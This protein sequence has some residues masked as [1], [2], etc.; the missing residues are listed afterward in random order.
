MPRTDSSGEYVGVELGGTKMV[1]ATSRGGALLAAREEVPTADPDSTL[2]AVRA[3]IRDVTNGML[4]KA[5]GLASFGPIDLR[6]HSDRF[7][8]LLNTPKPGWSGVNVLRALSEDLGVPTVIDTDVNAAVVA[9]KKWGAGRAHDHVAYLTVGTGVGGGIWSN[10]RLVRGS[11]HPEIGHIRVSRRSGDDH[12]SSCPFHEDCLEGM[13][14][15]TALRKRWGRGAEDLG[16]LTGAATRL[17]A[18]YLARG[19]AGM[20]S[21]VPIDMVIIGGGLSKLPGLHAGVAAALAEA[22]GSYP[23]VPFAEGGPIIASPEL[24]DDS[25]VLGAIEMARIVKQGSA[26]TPG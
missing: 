15:G 23:S 2:K 3:A 21:V 1:I 24:G 22:S 19:I 8:E 20:C 26:K 17:E 18:W 7:G 14:S 16:H 11:N 4:P 5:L 6:T 25:G 10:G 12:I 9:E 13:A